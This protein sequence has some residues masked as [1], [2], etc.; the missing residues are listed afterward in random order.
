MVKKSKTPSKKKQKK[1]SPGEK[2]SPAEEENDEVP[3]DIFE[4]PASDR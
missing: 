1:E 3:V 2:D 4:A